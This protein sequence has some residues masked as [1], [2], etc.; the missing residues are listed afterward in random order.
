MG[1]PIRMTTNPDVRHAV[2]RAND[3]AVVE[4][5][6]RLGYAANGLIHLLI[7]WIAVQIAFG[8]GGGKNAD[9]SGALGTL[10]R[11]SWGQA[12]LWVAVAGFVLLVVWEITEV[13]LRHETTDRVKAAAKAVAYGAL[14]WTA[15]TFATGGHS[16]SNKTTKD[17]TATLMN[18]PGGQ[19]LVGAVGVGIVVIGGYHVYKGWQ[20]K[21]MEDLEEHPGHFAEV[22]GRVGYIAK[23]VALA[24]VGFLFVVAAIQHKAGKASGLDGALRTLRDAPMGTVLLVLVGLGIAAFGVYCFARARFAR[25]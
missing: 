11:E 2:D 6:A 7:A 4:W 25:V 18:A 23:G 1:Y 19:L 3:S 5:G 8:S 13:F 17:F 20:R 14:G 12:L 16:N 24:V 10:A 21:F 15:F 22:A 9:Q